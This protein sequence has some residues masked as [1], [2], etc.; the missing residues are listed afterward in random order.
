[1]M[2]F[3]CCLIN[4]AGTAPLYCEAFVVLPTHQCPFEH[5]KFA[6]KEGKK[7]KARE[8]PAAAE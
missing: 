8:T 1:M 4:R 7:K 3:A 6:P 5:L 2:V